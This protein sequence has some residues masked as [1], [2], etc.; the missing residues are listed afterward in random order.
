MN[1]ARDPYSEW[2]EEYL[3][4]SDDDFEVRVTVRDAESEPAPARVFEPPEVDL[5]L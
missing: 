3:G 5:G 1:K 2:I 4:Q